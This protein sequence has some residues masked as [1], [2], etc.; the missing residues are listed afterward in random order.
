[1]EVLQKDGSIPQQW[2]INQVE[3]E[4]K[5]KIEVEKELSNLKWRFDVLLEKMTNLQN[6]AKKLADFDIENERNFIK[7]DAY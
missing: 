7:D 5:K 3:N 6:L 1:M 4:K 2:A